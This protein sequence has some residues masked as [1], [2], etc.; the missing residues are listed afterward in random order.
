M[1]IVVL[2]IWYPFGSFCLSK[3]HSPRVAWLLCGLK[4]KEGLESTLLCIF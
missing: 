2:F 1:A 4:A 3:E